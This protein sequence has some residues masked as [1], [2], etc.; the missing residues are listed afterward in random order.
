MTKNLRQNFE[1]R[2][3]SWSDEPEDSQST[4]DR[5]AT[6]NAWADNASR[7]VHELLTPLLQQPPC[8]IVTGYQDFLS[9]LSIIFDAVPDLLDNPPGSYRF[10]FGSNTETRQTIGG[11]SGSIDEEARRHFLGSRGF[12]VLDLADLRA[13]LAVEA[14]E[15]GIIQ[16]RIF[17]QDLARDQVG[18]RPAMLHAKLFAGPQMVC[19]AAPTSRLA[20]CVA[21]SS[22]LMTPAIGP[23]LPRLDALQRSNSGQWAAT[24]PKQRWTSCVT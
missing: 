22:S 8:L 5:R 18:R 3:V 1:S 23:N 12:S 15:R 19:Q 17:D 24:G 16:F 2:T 6:A 20:V 10:V 13:V 7:P 14:I 9:S 4:S 11:R 21:T